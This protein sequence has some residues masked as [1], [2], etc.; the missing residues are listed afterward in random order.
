MADA[1]VGT[2]PYM[3]LEAISRE[4]YSYEGDWWSLGVAF[5]E[6]L[7]GDVSSSLMMHIVSLTSCLQIP[8]YANTFEDTFLLIREAPLPYE[9]EVV[10]DAMTK[11]FLKVCPLI[12]F[13]FNN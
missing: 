4:P 9:V 11:D 7:T 5:H 1:F 10:F 6:M 2:I 8:W 12:D 3:S 13:L